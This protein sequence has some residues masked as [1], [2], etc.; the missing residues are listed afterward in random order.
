M[1]E[2][3]VIEQERALYWHRRRQE[4]PNPRRMLHESDELMYW[5]EECLVQELRLVPG[6][7]LPRLVALLAAADPRLPRRLGGERRPAQVLQL[8]YLAQ[9]ALM[10][11]STLER[12]PARVIPLFG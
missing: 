3:T 6:W 11:R 8:L 1:I 12:E 10:E 4:G 2:Q 5:L 7:L 9:Q